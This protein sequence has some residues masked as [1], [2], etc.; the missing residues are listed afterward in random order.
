MVAKIHLRKYLTVSIKFGSV[1]LHAML[2]KQFPTGSWLSTHLTNAL[3]TE[4]Y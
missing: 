1:G 2:T 3:T 4:Q